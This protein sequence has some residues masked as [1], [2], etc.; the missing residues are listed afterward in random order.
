MQRCLKGEKAGDGPPAKAVVPTLF[1]SFYNSH[2][3]IFYMQTKA[4]SMRTS[5]AK[6]S[7]REDDGDEK[8]AVAIESKQ[9]SKGADDHVDISR[10]AQPLDRGRSRGGTRGGKPGMG[11]VDSAGL[12]SLN[13]DAF[14]N[15][16][17]EIEGCDG[18][19]ATTQTLLGAIISKPKLT[20]KLLSKP[21]FR[22]L[23]D[24]I[25]EVTRTTGFSRGLYTEEELDSA[26]VQE[27]SQKMMY[28]EKMIKLIGVHLNTVVEARP[29][30]IVAG[31]EAQNTN[32]LLQLLAVA[33]GNRPD[34]S[35]SVPLALE[36]LSMPT[37]ANSEGSVAAKVPEKAAVGAV[38]R[39]VDAAETKVEER[40][41]RGRQP[42]PEAL[43]DDILSVAE[44]KVSGHPSSSR[45]AQ[46]A[47]DT[48][49]VHA[50][51]KNVT[52]NEASSESEPRQ[53]S[54]RPTTA[55]RRPPKVVQG[56]KDV[57]MQDAVV[58]KKTEG[59]IIDGQND[60]EE[61]IL[62]V[63][64][65]IRLGDDMKSDAKS[66]GV[67]SKIVKDIKSRQ[68]EQD[69]ERARLNEIKSLDSEE[70]KGASSGIRIGRLRKPG[71][72]GVFY[73][74]NVNSIDKFCTTGADKKP[75][76]SSTG[77]GDIEKLRSA[78]QVLVQQ[79]GPLGSTMDFIQ[80]DVGVMTAELR[81][82]EEESVK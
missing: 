64:D 38:S 15:L 69:A 57:G 12:G 44:E 31:L 32:V 81:K 63:E 47:E 52:E 19:E 70:A 72:L 26:N 71:A 42:A 36:Q 75:L 53:R 56:A 77:S 78:I 35:R 24:I 6:P 25:S 29:A 61:E 13:T 67:D 43:R 1:I 4:A 41:G 76:G 5:E 39:T 46:E 10:D 45:A 2:T 65:N 28:L 49:N 74:L 14:P 51:A 30:K 54:M 48:S 82:W 9:E 11:S 7:R 37:A 18:T 21:P 55:L 60:D 34:S 27:K 62:E 66:E 3:S 68:A 23:H 80:E 8:R 79:T 20:E 59:L 58:A 33:A 73:L 17:K 50:Q 22:F 16:D 40:N